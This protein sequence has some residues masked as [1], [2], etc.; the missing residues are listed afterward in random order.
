[1]KCQTC[2]RFTS[3]IRQTKDGPTAICSDC[4]E[5]ERQI[6]ETDLRIVTEG[7]HAG[8][9]VKLVGRKDR[10]TVF[11]TFED[12]GK[13]YSFNSSYLRLPKIEEI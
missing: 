1:M 3:I 8:K 7:R 13:E 6:F 9:R 5:K 12:G 11:I 10:F 2:N 4:Q